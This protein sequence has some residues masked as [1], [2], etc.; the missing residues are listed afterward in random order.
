MGSEPSDQLAVTIR[1]E[2]KDAGR[3]GAIVQQLERLGASEL[4]PHPRLGIINCN[5][6]AGQLEAS[7]EV[8]G[9]ASVRQE[10]SY[11]VRSH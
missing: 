11:G 6:P 7:R 5:L 3:F 9:V 4:A 10:R 8:E 2:P 1:I